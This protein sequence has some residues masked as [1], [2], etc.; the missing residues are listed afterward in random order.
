MKTSLQ[1]GILVL[2]GVTCSSAAWAQRGFH[3]VGVRPAMT[4]QR[5]MPIVAR[6]RVSMSQTPRVVTTTVNG[7]TSNAVVVSGISPLSLQDLLNP[8]PGFGFSFV[9][10]A[11]INRDLGIRALID[12]ATQMQLALAE[13]LLIETPVAPVAFPI[14]G[15]VGE[16]PV[17]IPQQQPQVII[18]QQPTPAAETATAPAA[19]QS[20]EAPEAAASAPLPDVG[21]FILVER[22]G[23]QIPAVAFTRQGDRIVYVTRQGTRRSMGVVELDPDATVRVN[24]ERGTP[25]QLPL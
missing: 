20:M 11:A 25:L 17:I 7:T 15:G 12:P 2:A 18:V 9:H 13:R 22:D 24:E 6:T 3:G 21:E 1:I 10:L 16:A 5:G 14:F 4:S 23:N 8:V 19:P